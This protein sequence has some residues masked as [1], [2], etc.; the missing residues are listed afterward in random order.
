MN[1]EKLP[2]VTSNV[3]NSYYAG[4]ERSTDDSGTNGRTR[5]I[6]HGLTIISVLIAA[7]FT[8]YGCVVAESAAIILPFFIL[9]SWI[10]IHCCLLFFG[11]KEH[12][13]FHPPEWFIFITSGHIILQSLLVIMLTLFKKS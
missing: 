7:S 3:D 2:L 8:I 6:L 13:D 12:H 5:R 11:Q 1:H 10:F 9:S 4:N